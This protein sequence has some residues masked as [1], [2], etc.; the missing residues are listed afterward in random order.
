MVLHEK[1]RKVGKVC[2]TCTGYVL[3]EESKTVVGCAV[4]TAESFKVK[5]RL[6][7]ELV[8]SSF[9]FTVIMDRITDE[10]RT[11]PPWMK[12]FA[13]D[14]VICK[15]TRKEMEWRLECW[16]MHWKEG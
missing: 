2:G 5:V 8:L 9:L 14:I 12:L 4:G 13:D 11:E 15:E 6:H 3:Y 1:I 16:S 7:Q 10:V